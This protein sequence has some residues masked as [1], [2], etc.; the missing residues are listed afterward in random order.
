MKTN[1]KKAITYR[2]VSTDEQSTG[3]SDQAEKL[4]AYCKLKDLIVIEDI[5]DEDISGAKPL[6][7]RPGG[8]RIREIKFDVIVAVKLDRLF[9]DASDCLLIT[10][11]WDKQNR[12]LH[13]IDMGG[14][15][16]DTSSAMGRMFITMTAGFAEM[17]RAM[18]S[19][20]VSAA[21]QYMRKHSKRVGGIPYGY[22]LS[23]DMSS[24][25]KS[26]VKEGNPR[27][28]VLIENPE[29]LYVLNVI[30]KLRE[31]G[32][33]LRAI[34][35]ILESKGIK[36]KRGGEKWQA[37]AIQSILERAILPDAVAKTPL[38]DGF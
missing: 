9:R 5:E 30:V 17:E 14:N 1:K 32:E 18:I 6:F 33:S 37:S 8:A 25:S 20:R 35:T 24:V 11:E 12:A 21:L 23:E 28:N 19:D 4:K 15:S 3:L 31:R 26:S 29:E 36:P 34:G 22:N 2:R 7:E 27:P 16:F 38:P 13:L 10:K